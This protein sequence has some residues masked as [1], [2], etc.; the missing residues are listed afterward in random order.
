MESPHPLEA[1][2]A[3]DATP[4]HLP[5]NPR[6][7]CLLAPPSIGHALCPIPRHLLAEGHAPP[8]SPRPHWLL[9]HVILS[10]SFSL[11]QVT[12]SYLSPDSAFNLGSSHSHL[13]FILRLGLGAWVMEVNQTRHCPQEIQG[14]LGDMDLGSDSDSLGW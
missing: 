6:L 8:R 13:S 7:H 11:A 14:M 1:K 2:K 4:P 9:F 10:R 5:G 3:F 12:P